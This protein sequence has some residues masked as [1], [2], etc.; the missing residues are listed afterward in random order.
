MQ[1]NSL[2]QDGA[3]L[4]REIFIPVWGTTAP[5]SRIEAELNGV[6]SYSRSSNTGYFILRLPPQQA[7]GPYTLTVRNRDNGEAV[8]VNDVMVGEV[9]LASGQSNMS[10]LLGSDWAVVLPGKESGT[11]KVNAAQLEEFRQGATDGDQFRFF[12]VANDATA[13]PKDS[14]VGKWQRYTPTNCGD[15][16]AVGSWFGRKLREKLNVPVGIIASAWGG[17]IAAAWTSRAGLL[18]N[19]VTATLPYYFSQS[20]TD[21]ESWTRSNEGAQWE[22]LTIKDPGNKGFDMGYASQG[23]VDAK[24]LDMTMPGSWI[25]QDIAGNGAV[26]VRGK[27][28]LPDSWDGKDIVLHTGGIDKHDTSYFNGVEVG[29]T[30]KDFETDYWNAPREYKIPG[31]LVKAGRNVIAIRAYSFIF[32]G[33]FW[34][35]ADDY[36]LSLEETGEKIGIAGIWKAK[37][38]LDIGLRSSAPS[39]TGFGPGNPNTPSILFDGMI[40]PL[41]PYAIRG[42]IWYQGESDAK[43]IE[44]SKDYFSKLGTM[45]KDWRYQWAQGDFPFIQTELANYLEKSLY[46][47]HSTWAVLR[48][49]QR[50]L[51][52]SMRDVYLGSAIDIGEAADIHPQNKKDVGFRLAYNALR[53]VYHLA[54]VTPAGPWLKGGSREGAA[55]RLVFD[56]AEGLHLTEDGKRSFYVGDATGA[57]VKADSVIVEGNTLLVSA[58]EILFPTAVR[59]AWSD[60]PDATLYNAAGLPCGTFCWE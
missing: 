27:V 38:E 33:C 51:C 5:N 50:T 14:A 58:K 2:F 53:N 44:D 47:K 40:R 31:K 35:S 4:Q 41:I 57:F 23:F 16:C 22:K 9:W 54:D 49:S 43:T 39:V 28:E 29:R 25:R 11:P 24:W 56:N 8:T 1:L 42:A 12:M 18:S 55:I 59:Y 10:Y 48:N 32:E 19:P 3:V 37:A 7:G 21:E 46:D 26:W 20:L 15:A 34:G 13:V 17:T 60:N 45:I 6:K 36:Y 52:N 30:G